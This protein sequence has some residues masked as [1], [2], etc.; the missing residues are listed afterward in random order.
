M[1]GSSDYSVKTVLMWS[2]NGITT[3]EEVAAVIQVRQE[4]G[5]EQVVRGQIRRVPLIQNR[6]TNWAKKICRNIGYG[7]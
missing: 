2:K 1:K 3:S 6:V 7:V 5:L 4:D